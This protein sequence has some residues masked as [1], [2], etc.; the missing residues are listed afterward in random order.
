MQAGIMGESL[1]ANWRQEEMAPDTGNLDQ[2]LTPLEQADTLCL[3]RLATA[4][5]PMQIQGDLL[6]VE[7]FT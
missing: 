4:K 6:A 1:G 3:L 2:K 7:G 5:K